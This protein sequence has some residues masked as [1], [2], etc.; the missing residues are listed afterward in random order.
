[1]SYTWTP[2]AANA[3]YTIAVHVRN[4]GEAWV[5][6][7]QRGLAFPITG[8]TAPPVPT[9]T[10]LTAD[11]TAPQPAGTSITFT[12]TVTGGTGSFESRWYV[13][14]GVSWMLL[15]GWEAGL[16]YTWT[17]AAANANYTI[18]VHVRNTGEAWVSS[19]QRGLAFPITEGP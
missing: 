10:A 19:S 12:A 4:A 11:K 17:P 7:N 2:A 13:W 18:A 3:N 15:R 14:D 9:V 1:L 6:S 5:S 8:E 16:S